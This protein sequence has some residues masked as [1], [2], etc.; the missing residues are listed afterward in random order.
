MFILAYG[1]RERVCK[2]EKAQQ[3]DGAM[4]NSSKNVSRKSKAET[5]SWN[6]AQYLTN[7]SHPSQ[8]WNWT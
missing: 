8:I 2:A 3:G 4:G 1:S 5:G 7:G 6:W